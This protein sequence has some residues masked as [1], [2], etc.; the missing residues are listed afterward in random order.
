MKPPKITL[1]LMDLR[2]CLC[3]A[4]C[5]IGAGPTCWCGI[6]HGELVSWDYCSECDRGAC[7]MGWVR[8]FDA[9]PSETFPE[10]TIDPNCTMP[11]AYQIEVGAVR[12]YPTMDDD[13]SL[14]DEGAIGEAAMGM[15]ADM[16]AMHEALRCCTSEHITDFVLGNY[17]PLGPSGACAGGAWT[18]WIAVA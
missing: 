2:D 17:L 1:A 16:E 3:S 6:W 14:P 8:L 15:I 12:C 9:A 5:E 18:A 7:G 4:L 10:A 13:G 11:L